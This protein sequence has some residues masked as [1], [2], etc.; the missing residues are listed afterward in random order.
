MRRTLRAFRLALATFSIWPIRFGD[1]ELSEADLAASRFAYPI[2]GLLI[3]LVLAGLSVG[4]SRLGARADLAAVLILACW[5]GLS[6]GLHLDGLA[7][8]FD[9]LFLPGGPERR[10]AVM[11]DPHVGSFGVVGVVLVLLGKFAALGGL[12]PPVRATALLGAAAAG[13][14]AVLMAA[15]LSRYARPEGTGRVLIDATRPVD[16]AFAILLVFL[17][18]YAST[19]MAGLIAAGA[20]VGLVAGLTTLAMRRLGGTT[21]DI[22]GAVV[23]SGELVFLMAI[24]LAGGS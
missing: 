16:A 5:V 22:L 19:G 12:T 18:G 3:G 20:V 7:D 15:G 23:E 24:G 8:T 10:L 9:G 11:R 4:L 1:G 13:R 17:I 21:G 2:V 6:G 14:I